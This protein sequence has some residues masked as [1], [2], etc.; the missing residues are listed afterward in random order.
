LFVGPFMAEDLQKPNMAEPGGA[1]PTMPEHLFAMFLKL[2]DRRCVVV[3]G[4]AAAEGKT[5]ALLANGAKV[6]VIAPQATSKITAWAASGRL[7]WQARE[8]RSSD[9]R[10]AFLVVSA[11]DDPELNAQVFALADEHG[12]LCNA[13]DDPQHCHFYFPSVVDRGPL[14]IAISTS[15]NSPALAQ[16]LRRELERQY[17]EEYAAWVRHLGASRAQLFQEPGLDPEVRRQLLHLQASEEAFRAFL[18]KGETTDFGQTSKDSA[19]GGK[20][21]LVG[22]GPGDPEL[23]TVKATRVL[24]T[25]EVVLHDD[26]VGPEILAMIPL[27][28]EVRSVGKRAG[29]KHTP[30]AE[31]NDL[32]LAYARAGK[33]VV[34][35]KG[36]DPLLFGRAGEEMEALR[37]AGIRFEVV[38]G[39]TAAL[40]AA[41]SAQ[42]PLTDRRLA[43]SVLFASGHACAG[44]AAID[45][46]A[47]VQTGATLVVYMPGNHRNLA[48]Q[49]LAAGLDE[50]TPCAVISQASLPAEHIEGMSL[51]G[52]AESTQPAKPNLL[53]VGAVAAVMLQQ[54]SAA[55]SS[56]GD[57]IFEEQLVTR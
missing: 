15:G 28:A 16:R 23:L 34:R 33:R 20:V 54:K 2:K 40:G 18:A 43:S 21:Y 31:I 1:E 11:S 41:A 39:V 17:G 27:Q 7:T 10:D 56:E 37:A 53:I 55:V 30:Q 52:L 6:I 57:S 44:N 46:A 38:P 5:Q 26:L 8:F 22:A 3:G 29:G 35:L 4:G 14:Q 51:R 42:I 25:A 13:V 12:I 24:Q 45:W 49:L 36:G 19:P 50:E 9:L 32:L 47:A 48:A